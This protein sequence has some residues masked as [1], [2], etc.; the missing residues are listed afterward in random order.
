MAD[1]F[2]PLAIAHVR[3]KKFDVDMKDGKAVPWVAEYTIT[4]RLDR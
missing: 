2:D 1:L 4:W 3:A